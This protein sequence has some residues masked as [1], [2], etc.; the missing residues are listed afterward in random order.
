MEKRIEVSFPGN[1]RVD[2]HIGD[3]TVK[4]DQLKRNGGDETATQP[5]DLFFISL[6]TCAG[7]S[8]LDYCQERSLPT[9]GLGVALVATRHPTQ[10]RYDHVRI[11]VAVPAGIQD[12]HV[13]ALLAEAGDCSVKRHILNPPSFEVVRI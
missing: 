3:M 5:F 12:A 10:P 13:E 9:D 6:A 2:A 4:T 8:V 1:K 11:E 7:I